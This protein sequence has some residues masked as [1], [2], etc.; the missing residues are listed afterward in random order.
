MTTG[1][2]TLVG[3]FGFDYTMIGIACDGTGN[4]YGVT[5]D[6]TLISDLYSIDLSTGVATSIGS[7]GGQ[8]LYAQDL[9]YDK[10]NDI[11]YLAAYFGDGTP[12][13]L[14]QIDTTTAAMTL[15]GNFQGGMEVS[16]FAIPY[17]LIPPV[18]DLDCQGDLN[19][20][21]VQVGTPVTD[22]FTVSNIGDPGSLLDWE[23]L[24]EPNWGSWSYS[25]A[26]YG[27]DLT[28][29]ASPHPVTV[30]VDTTTLNPD[31]TY[32]GEIVLVNSE[33]PVDTCSIPVSLVTPV[34]QQLDLYTLCQ[35]I[36]E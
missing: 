33:N 26:D 22:I 7:T 14:Y 1:A 17:T 30:T 28:P 20:V 34:S 12:S 2:A 25:P 15:I 13:G 11:S 36:L 32:S 24:V 18:P 23:V 35:R 31:T 6:F 8:L 10:N 9:A 21:D 5:V 19:W 16:G 27:L 4:C 29:G 3:S